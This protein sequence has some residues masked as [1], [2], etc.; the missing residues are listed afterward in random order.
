MAPF[1]KA[2]AFFLFRAQPI[3]RH[4]ALPASM[5]LKKQKVSAKC[6]DAQYVYTRV[7]K[8]DVKN[9]DAIGVQSYSHH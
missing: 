8:C 2:R 4:R 3:I 5:S 6:S 9:N 1:C 7:E